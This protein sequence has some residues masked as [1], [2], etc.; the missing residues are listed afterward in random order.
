MA[1]LR[2]T[3]DRIQRYSSTPWYIT[4]EKDFVRGLLLIGEKGY[5]QQL[6]KELHKSAIKQKL[7][8]Q[9]DSIRAL[10]VKAA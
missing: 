8:N 2:E 3:H 10:S 7:F 1:H 4:I 9:A 5:A 6:L